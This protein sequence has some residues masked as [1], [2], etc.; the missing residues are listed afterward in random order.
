M[1]CIF[2]IHSSVEGHLDSFQLLDIINNAA[3]NTVAHV[4]L[5]D[6]LLEHL[7]GICP[8]VLKLSPHVVLCLIFWGT[9][10]LISRVVLLAWNP[11]SNGGVFL[12][13]HILFTICCPVC[14]RSN[15]HR[16]EGSYLCLQFYVIDLPTCHCTNTMQ[17]LSLLLCSVVWGQAQR[18]LQKFFFCWQ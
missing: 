15:D 6:I 14:Q 1:Y 5:L 17:F 2:C 3:M 12:F 9:A 11:T 4:S 10:K 8:E 13:L 18:F 7:L 16:C